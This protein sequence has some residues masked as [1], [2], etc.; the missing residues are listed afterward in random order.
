MR[1]K[2]SYANDPKN[3]WQ[4]SENWRKVTKSA[5]KH[6]EKFR[7][8]VIGCIFALF[9]CCTPK[10]SIGSDFGVNPKKSLFF[11]L[12]L[13]PQRCF[14]PT[15]KQWHVTWYSPWKHS[16]SGIVLA[17]KAKTAAINFFENHQELSQKGKKQSKKRIFS[18]ISSANIICC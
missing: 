2:K 9:Q 6:F 4:V 11:K 13:L 5:V 14:S 1:I 7:L 16:R 12:P 3:F 8:F 18:E 15:L 10:S 17:K